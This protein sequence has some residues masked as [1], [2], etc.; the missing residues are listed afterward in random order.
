M[1]TE[2][3]A[4]VA[5]IAIVVANHKI[6]KRLQAIAD[7]TEQQL[8][9]IVPE[10]QLAGRRFNGAFMGRELYRE[11]LS[12]NRGEQWYHDLQ[13]RLTRHTMIVEL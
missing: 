8:H 12:T 3:P 11:I 9:Y 5:P 1:T 4:W 6:A 7:H 13:L 10:Q 2:T